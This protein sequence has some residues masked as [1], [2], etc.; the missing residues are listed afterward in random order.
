MNLTERSARQMC[1]EDERAIT[2]VL[3]DYATALDER[4]WNLLR[5]CFA[6]DC[7][8]EYV[9][10]GKWRGPAE[11][12][13]YMRGAH[14]SLGPTLHRISNIKVSEQRGQVFARS[15]VDALLMSAHSG[16]PVHRG[17]G[18]Y[19]DVIVRTAEGWKISRRK[20]TPVQ[21]D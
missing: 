13:E 4:D 1:V 3:L 16:G 10:F 6:I 8:A 9:G 19:E 21:I 20:F 5:S 2:A 15:Y 17:V 7:E 11:L 12:V 18:W 14:Q